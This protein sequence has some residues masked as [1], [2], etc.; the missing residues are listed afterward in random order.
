[1]KSDTR[2]RQLNPRKAKR[3]NDC[4]ANFRDTNIRLALFIDT[5]YH[6]F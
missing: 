4:T 3:I 1:M 5:N 6:Y 2:L